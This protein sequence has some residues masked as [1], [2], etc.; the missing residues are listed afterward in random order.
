VPLGGWVV[1]VCCTH[2]ASVI[3]LSHPIH[4]IHLHC[5]RPLPNNRKSSKVITTHPAM[6]SPQSS[7]ASLLGNAGARQDLS[8]DRNANSDEAILDCE[9]GWEPWRRLPPSRGCLAQPEG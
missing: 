8:L 4:N 7:L 3:L 6:T 5:R 2:F 1:F 9:C